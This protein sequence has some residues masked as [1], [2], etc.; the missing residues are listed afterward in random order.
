[1]SSH[2]PGEDWTCSCG[3][4]YFGVTAAYSWQ[5]FEAHLP[6]AKEGTV[7]QVSNP[8]IHLECKAVESGGYRCE[9]SGPHTQHW[10]SEHTIAHAKL[11]NGYACSAIDKPLLTW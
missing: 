7:C 9:R 2:E 11:G 1:M 8:S 5:L 3:Y 6:R 10:I 4:D